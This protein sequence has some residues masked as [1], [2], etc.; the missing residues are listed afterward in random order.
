MPA[1]VHDVARVAG[2][3]IKT[4]S[5]VVN[6]YAHISPQ[7]KRKVLEAIDQLDY[8]PNLAARN[9]RMG[10]SGVIGL[11]I[12]DL[13][14]VYF[15]ELAADVMRAAERHGL[16]V[17]IEMVN[18]RKTET[19]ALH[20]SRI[21][22]T[23]GVLYSALALGQ[24]DVDLL[25]I[26]TPMVLLGDRIFNGPKDHVTIQNTEGA[27]RATQHLI[28]TG[29]RKIL[30]LGSHEGE[31]IGSAGL[32]LEGYR[33]GLEEADIDYDA[34]LVYPAGTWLR[35]DGAHAMREAL[36]AQVVFDAVFAFNDALAFGAMRVLQE[37]GLRIPS[38]VALIGFDDI[39][40]TRYSSPTLS[41]IDPGRT[42]IAERAVD[43][44][45][46][47]MNGETDILPREIP[48]DF[49][50]VVRESTS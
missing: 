39:D 40:E 4:V 32:R 30:V 15:A 5:N 45:V 20:G 6:N 8:T 36:K 37:A 7:T 11:I 43:A 49:R 19:A 24:E 44:L 33:Q 9:L 3:S 18:D 41:T 12:P 22:M 21:Q 14:N 2:V 47:R 42:E 10:K 35:S 27:K 26:P 23:D 48:A 34:S 31:L 29:R 28:E 46:Q 13:R 25:D 1:T 17:L 16:A 38:D 50:L